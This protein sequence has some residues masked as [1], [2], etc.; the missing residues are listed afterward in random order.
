MIRQIY[1]SDKRFKRITFDEGLNI[2]LAERSPKSGKKGTRNGAGKTTLI[3]VIH[4]CLGADLSRLS[5]P[6]EEITNWAF[7]IEIDICNELITAQRSIDDP[8]NIFI[9][10][11]YESLP[12]KPQ[13]DDD[14]EKYFYNND[15]WKKLLGLCLFDINKQTGTKYNPTFRGLI[16][17]FIRRNIDAYNDPFSYFRNQQKYAIQIYNSFLLGLNWALASDLQEIKEKEKIARSFSNAIKAGFISTLG[18]FEA[19]RVR[20]EKEIKKDSDAIANFKVHPQYKELH[21]KAD[22]LTSTIHS[23][24]NQLLIVRRKRERYEE[25]VKTEKVPDHRSV[26]SL[27]EEAGLLFPDTVKKTLNEA[28]AFHKSI[29]LNRKNF[30]QAE[31]TQINNQADSIE[32]EIKTLTDKRSSLMQLLQ[33]HGALEEFTLLQERLL[34]KKNNLDSIKRKI[35]D[36]KEASRKKK[37]IKAS[38]IEI[39]TKSQRDYEQSRPS[40]EKAIELFNDNT[41]ALYDEPGDL[42]INVTENGYDFDVHIQKSGSEGV[43]KMK[44]FCYDLTLVDLWT[45]KRKI[46]FLIH[47]STIYD[48]VD[49]RQRALALIGAKNKAEKSGF[50][51]ICALNSDNIP[52]DDLEEDFDINQHIRLKLSDKDPSE[53]LFGFHFEIKKEEAEEEKNETLF[54]SI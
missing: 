20:F 28:K 1:A 42:I 30:L 22:Q 52:H 39:E 18:D 45:Q 23:L 47:D 26:E 51:Y 44:I 31:L 15:T 36:I 5:L 33:T 54:T 12:I 53:S 25:S 3:H 17:Y 7:Y 2:I 43:G 8:N 46:D 49:S 19:E 4:F 21:E 40:W 48:G 27:Y 32:N 35:S 41:Y 11:R 24:S 16:S 29:V 38:K 37:E 9:K 6:V 10:G 14:S 13:K 34:E 50:Q